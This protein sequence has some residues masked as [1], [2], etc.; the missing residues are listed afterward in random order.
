[1]K[2]LMLKDLY[3]IRGFLKQVVVIE[4]F[5]M[6]MGMFMNNPSIIAF[7]LLFLSLSLVQ[8]CMSV[9][10]KNRWERYALTMPFRRKDMVAS[11]YLL[12]TAISVLMGGLMLVLNT[13]LVMVHGGNLGTTTASYL[14]VIV[15]YLIVYEISLP[16]LYKMGVERGRYVMMGI[17]VV[18]VICAA[19]AAEYLPQSI[20]Q[21]LAAVVNEQIFVMLGAGIAAAV[22]GMWLSYRVSLAIYRKKEF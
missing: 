6:A 8:A 14:A 13:I 1:M 5:L 21:S 11:K 9:D 20:L 17:F 19:I 3:C 2:A 15:V 16:F 22:L 4:V 12:L 18:P 7:G 10:E